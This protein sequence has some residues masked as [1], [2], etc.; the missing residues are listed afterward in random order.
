MVRLIAGK[1]PYGVDH[2][3]YRT[4]SAKHPQTAFVKALERF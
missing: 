1:S 4:I 2:R 3:R